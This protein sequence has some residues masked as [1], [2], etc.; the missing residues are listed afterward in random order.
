MTDA[1]ASDIRPHDSPLTR[2]I[3]GS[4]GSSFLAYPCPPMTN[5]APIPLAPD[6]PSP[7]VPPLWGRVQVSADPHEAAEALGS[8]LMEQAHACVASM[9]D[10]H[11]AL[12]GGSTP[13]PFYQSLMTDPMYRRLPWDRTH[14][15]IVDERRVPFDHPK[16]NWRQ[17]HEII[18]D[19][20]GIPP[21]QA[22]PIEAMEQDAAARYERA[23][24]AAFSRR[25]VTEQRLDF[26]LLGM[27][28]NGHTASLFPQ[29]AALRERKLLV[30]D[31]DGPTVTPP[32]RVTM[33]Y[34]LL[35]AARSVAVLALGSEK[36]PMIHRVATGS[37]D[38][39][40][41]P[42]KNIRPSG[43]LVWHLDRASAAPPNG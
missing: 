39:I 40:A 33:T 21:A 20:S 22:H 34:P 14:L 8:D 31:C 1:A 7:S 10:F 26:V 30:C 25:A 9:G 12:S 36:A 41:L 18:V 19:H 42:I 2:A 6:G 37:D 13:F 24:R 4:G 23:L 28:D 29:T 38:F 5:D 27:G 32:A 3:G 11:L 16:S 43:T 35:N 15:W 17:I